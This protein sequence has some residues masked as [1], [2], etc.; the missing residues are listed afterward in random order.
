MAYDTNNPLGSTDFRDLSDNAE[1]FDRFANGPAPSY[2]N[3]FGVSKIS[4]SGMQ[5]SFLAAQASRATVFQ[6]TLATFGYSYL[7]DYAAGLTFT[8][9]QQY[10]LR[11]GLAYSVDNTTALPYTL[12]GVWAT[13]QPKLKIVSADQVL[14]TDL[15]ASTGATLVNTTSGPLQTVLDRLEVFK[16]TYD[17][18]V[19]YGQSNALGLAGAMGDTSGWPTPLSTSLMYD[20]DTG[21]IK[22]IIQNMKSVNGAVSSG[23]SWGEFANEYFRKT[24]RG[25]IVV[26]AARGGMAIA[27]LIKGAGTGY[28]EGM[29]AGATA[30][31]T[32]A[33][34]AGYNIGSRM[35][36]WHQG[37]S[38]MSIDPAVSPTKYDTYYGALNTLIE[39]LRTDFPFSFFGICTVGCPP[40][41]LETS[42]GVTQNA[43]RTLAQRR[44]D[45]SIVFDGCPTFFA[46][47]GMVN[48]SGGDEHYSQKA[49]NLMGYHAAQGFA[50]LFSKG[51]RVKSSVDLNEYGGASKLGPAWAR[52]QRSS[53]RILWHTT[54]WRVSSKQLDD[55][56]WR[57]SGVVEVKEDTNNLY[58]KFDNRADFI[59]ET[60]AR[61]DRISQQYGIGVIPTKAQFGGEDV[62]QLEFYIDLRIAANLATGALF[63]NRP[64]STLPAWLSNFITAGLS[65][66]VLSIT[67]GAT[68]LIP[69]VC[70]IG[71]A[72]GFSG[73]PAALY[74]TAPTN[75][76]TRVSF[77][78]T[79]QPSYPLVALAIDKVKM[80]IAA[81]KLLDGF[82]CEFGAT[83]APLS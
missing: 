3:R 17:L 39:N 6:N 83:I 72:D 25:V 66:G 44:A 26:N 64:P 32:A 79:G 82:R 7:G 61:V 62:L 67:H 51:T 8:T 28:Y 69:Q 1:N 5:E 2:P 70:H 46:A 36:C 41:R 18:L 31:V 65:G 56:G 68:T 49:Y 10:V 12:T 33:S 81:L 45:T 53:G 16:G 47:D 74:L 23:H 48:A 50:E 13:D 60:Y 29:V 54:G 52:A 24:Q 20:V 30:A 59:F 77:A 73:Q 21:T 11:N 55:A 78:T 75:T 76:L 58:V 4:I 80:P 71:G 9:R 19:V 38:D 57:S 34:A 42:W 40:S 43:Q 15:A 35:V 27:S 22:P 37:E 14:R 63:F